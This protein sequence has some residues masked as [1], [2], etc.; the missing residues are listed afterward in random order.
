M[1]NL[2]K[3]KGKRMIAFVLCVLM[4]VTAIPMT[5]FAWTA[6]EG[7]VC[8]SSFGDYYVGYD[9]EHYYSAEEYNYLVYDSNG[10]TTSHTMY[11]GGARRKYLLTNSA[12]EN[13]HVYCVESGVEYASSTNAYTSKSGENSS[14]FQNLPRLAQTGIM[15]TTVYGWQPGLSSPVSG[16]NADDYAIA[17]QIIM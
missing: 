12:G 16:T 14:Y 7:V 17:T 9:G 3:T 4:S 6:D 5:A 11:A 1:K 10:N 8:S 13:R 15:L 2:L